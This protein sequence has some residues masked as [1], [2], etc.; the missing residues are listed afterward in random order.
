MSESD[1]V[2]RLDVLIKLTAL[3][4]IAGKSITD[5]VELL[6]SAGLKPAEISRIIGKPLNTITGLLARLKKKSNKSEER[7]AS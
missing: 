2:N 7:V 6:S 1:L 4:M 5:Q 3:N